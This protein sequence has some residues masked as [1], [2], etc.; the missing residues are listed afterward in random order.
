MSHPMLR[1]FDGTEGTSPDLQ[2]DVKELQTD[3]NRFGFNVQVDGIFGSETEASVHQ[4]QLDHNLE[5]DGIVGPQTWAALTGT[6]AP[7][8]GSTFPTTI[9]NNNAGMQADFAEAR[10]FKALIDAGAQ[11]I[12]VP[13]VVI[14]GIGSRES[15]WGLANRPPGPA[16]TGDFGQRS[17]PTSFRT[18][19][20]PD[21]GGFGRGL[22]Q[23]D[24][25]ASEFARTGNWKDP[26]ANINA[27]C[28]VLK[29]SLDLLGRRTSLTGRD[30]LQA[31]IAAYNCGAGNVL[32]AISQGRPVDFFTTGRNYSQDVLNRAGFFQN[33]GWESQPETL[34]A[35]A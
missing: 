4:F 20:L 35:I 3:L 26:E 7:E 15:R 18:G 16:G 27:G 24:F 13:S 25:D 33:M 1:L 22:M 32:K 10:K 31:A 19:P 17:F 12:G 29:S 34:K 5:S 14:A 11:R 9:S 6:Q 21:D 8:P 30:L 23:I 28:N 2:D